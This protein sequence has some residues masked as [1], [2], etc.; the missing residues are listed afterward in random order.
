[1]TAA[2]AQPSG[3]PEGGPYLPAGAVL[4]SGEIEAHCTSVRPLITPFR[5]EALK[6]A[7]YDVVI[8]KDG[9]ILP[10][11]QIFKPGEECTRAL[12]LRPGDTAFVRTNETFDMPGWLT[13]TISIKAALAR[14]GVLL[15][16]GLVVDPHYRQGDG[17]DGRLHFTLANLGGETVVIEPHYT[18]VVTIQFIRTSGSPPE[19][20]TTSSAS[21]IWQNPQELAQLTRGLGFIAELRDLRTQLLETRQRLERQSTLTEYALIAGLFLLATTILGVSAAS[22]LSAA[23]DHGIVNDVKNAIPGSAG[24]R[25]FL[26]VMALSVAWIVFS[27][28]QAVVRVA[29]PPRR[30]PGPDNSATQQQNFISRSALTAL[31]VDHAIGRTVAGVVVLLL[32][33]ALV[34]ASLAIGDVGTWWWAIPVVVSIIAL[35]AAKAVKRLWRPIHAREINQRVAELYE[36]STPTPPTKHGGW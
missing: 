36:R 35:I 25:V 9:M 7:A 4:S 16:T 18:A 15:L 30:D 13:G 27:L 26:I 12:I 20:P 2:A 6:P 31:R 33:T 8:A 10:D 3:P 14:Q 21:H 24:K 23:S 28:S 22:I 32:G 1:M 5:E 29:S 34:E 17:N 11:G 19:R